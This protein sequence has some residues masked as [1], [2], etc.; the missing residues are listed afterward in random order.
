MLAQNA[1][2]CVK[3]LIKVSHEKIQY[4]LCKSIYQFNLYVFMLESCHKI[5]GMLLYFIHTYLYIY[6]LQY[7][8]SPFCR[9][10]NSYYGNLIIF[11]FIKL[12][13]IG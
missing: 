6:F 2:L 11:F 13:S 8:S 4:L 7:F 1:I 10:K 12:L 3:M 9:I 5:K